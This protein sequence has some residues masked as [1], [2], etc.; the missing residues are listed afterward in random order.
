MLVLYNQ[1]DVTNLT[2][3][4]LQILYTVLGVALI[5]LFAAIGL[6]L[7][8]SVNLTR[9]IQAIIN[10][11]HKIYEENDFSHDPEI[12]NREDEIGRIGKAVNE[13]SGNIGHFLV[14]TEEHYQEQKRTQIALLQTQL[15]PHFLYNTLDSIQWM[16]KIQSNPTIADFTRRLINLLRNIATRTAD[17]AGAKITVGEELRILEDYTE[18]MSVRFMGSFELANRIP[19]GFLDYR[20]PKLTLQP[21][22][23]NAILHGIEPSGRFVVITLTAAEDGDYLLIIVEDT[24]VGISPEQ[25]ETIKTR[26]RKTGPS[27]PSLNNIGIAN[28]DK[29]LRLL[30]DKTCGLFY[31]SRQGEYT[32]VTVRILKEKA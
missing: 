17:G 32:R 5:S 7:V 11:I 3:N 1:E 15:N 14:R 6:G 27:G 21:L 28:V 20:I 26:N 29:Q 30:Y 16:A 23:E 31:E 10:R 25:L 22:V 18:V 24:G 13:M 2:A 8:L 19:E 9:P 12:G 4:D